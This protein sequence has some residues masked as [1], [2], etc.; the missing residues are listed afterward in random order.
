MNIV[1]SSNLERNILAS[2][3]NVAKCFVYAGHDAVVWDGSAKPAFDIWDE[4]RPSVF[5]SNSLT[6]TEAKLCREFGTKHYIANGALWADLFMYKP[7]KPTQKEMDIFGCDNCVIINGDRNEISCLFDSCIF[8]PKATKHTKLFS[9]HQYMHKQYSQVLA[10]PLFSLALSC[11]KRVYATN[12]LNMFNFTLTNENC[13][14]PTYGGRFSRQDV[15][16][17]KVAFFGAEEISNACD[18]E[19]DFMA[20]YDRFMENYNG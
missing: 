14:Y 2:Y 11:A 4:L 15:L 17:N 8:G 16:D 7:M 1:I 19:V 5:V 6:E 20:E 3:V 18:L 13:Y 9:Q 12:F 10:E